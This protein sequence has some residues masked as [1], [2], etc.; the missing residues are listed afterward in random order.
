MA[1]HLSASKHS[2]N[3]V[4]MPFSLSYATK[5]VKDS[6]EGPMYPL[7][8]P[9][10]V[11]VKRSGDVGPHTEQL[12]KLSHE[13]EVNLVPRSLRTSLSMPILERMDNKALVTN[14]KSTS[15]ICTAP[16]NQVEKSLS[17]SS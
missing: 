8:S 11:G 12:V 13:S 7:R 1:W 5:F 16:R 17:V 10:T 2:W 3:K 6:F 15:F 9:I 4:P 14:T